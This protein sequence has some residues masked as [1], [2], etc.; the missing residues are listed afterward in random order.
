M[1]FSSEIIYGP[2]ILFEVLIFW[3]SI[4]WTNLDGEMTRNKVVDINEI[5]NSVVDDFFIRNHLQF[6]NYY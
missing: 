4:V 5:S 1:T 2:N 3:N 6:R